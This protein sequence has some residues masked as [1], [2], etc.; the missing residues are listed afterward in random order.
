MDSSTDNN[1]NISKDIPLKDINLLIIS[2]EGNILENCILKI[3]QEKDI[4][5]KQNARDYSFLRIKK[6][7]I[8]NSNQKNLN[9][10][11]YSFYSENLQNISLLDDILESLKI[12]ENFLMILKISPFCINQFDNKINNFVNYFKTK[13]IKI[14]DIK[15]IYQYGVDNFDY[16]NGDLNIKK[17]LKKDLQINLQDCSKINFFNKDVPVQ[18]IYYNEINEFFESFLYKKFIFFRKIKFLIYYIKKT[19]K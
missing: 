12:S 8:R 10:N 4:Q 13:S 16:P 9:F 5:M 6:F 11:L 7:F 2:D 14:K 17:N 15:I 19:K 1:N 3:F 18:V